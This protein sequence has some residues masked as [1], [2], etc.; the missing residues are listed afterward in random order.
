MLRA[1]ASIL[2]PFRRFG[3]ARRGS[4]A[5]EFALVAVPFF[6]LTVGLA[7]V[8]L[9]GYAQTTLDYAVS[10]EARRIR[11]GE[12]QTQGVSYAQLQADLCT[13]MNSLMVVSCS[14]NLYLDVQRFDSF[15]SA[16]NG[17][18]TPI[19]NGQFQTT[20]FGFTPGAASDIVVVRT[21]YRWKILTPMFQSFFANAGNGER[22]LVSTMM[23]RNEPF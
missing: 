6:M 4:A 14:N 2:R 23:F 19:Q 11:I 18:Q 7:E 3:R 22:I 10:E 16:N 1:L 5:V 9:I 8:A 21:Y 20:G 13:Q 17:N 12:V 15:V